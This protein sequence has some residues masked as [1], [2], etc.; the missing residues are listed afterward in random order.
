MNNILERLQFIRSIMSK[1]IWNDLEDLEGARASALMDFLD[2]DEHQYGDRSIQDI[3]WKAYEDW[4]PNSAN[5]D[6]WHIDFSFEYE[7]LMELFDLCE[8]YAKN[9]MFS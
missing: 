6:W 8:R 7:R 3:F 2:D 1:E 9:W 4:Y 5:E